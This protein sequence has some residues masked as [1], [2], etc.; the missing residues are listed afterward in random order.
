MK[1]LIIFDGDCGFCQKWIQRIMKWD[2][3]NQFEYVSLQ[4]P[5]KWKIR[6]PHLTEEHLKQAMYAISPDHT[7]FVGFDAFR[8]ISQGIP[9]LLWLKWLSHIPGV[10]WIGRH[11]YAWIATNR[12]RLGGTV[13]CRLP[14][15][16]VSKINSN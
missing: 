5:E 3:F 16:K 2:R 7:I 13:S 6:A 14:E 10:P 9:A 4:T 15:K 1:T 8:H 11:V 12:F